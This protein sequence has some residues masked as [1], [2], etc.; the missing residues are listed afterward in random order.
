MDPLAK[1]VR[2]LRQ[3]LGESQQAF[4][5]RLGLS[6][7]AI[8]NYEKDRRPTGMALL[9][10]ARAA[11]A[12]GLGLLT[13][14][15]MSAL[16]EE[17]RLT[18]LPFTWMELKHDG[19]DP[20]GIMLAN[21]KGRRRAEYLMAFWDCLQELDSENLEHQARATERLGALKAAV[22]ADSERKLPPWAIKRW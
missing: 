9:A 17:L 6:I 11:A 5:T 13:D 15:F 22:D 12:A 7:R 1:D 18:E 16:M 10:L 19:K 20:H 14:H 8:A 4:A 3:H 21:V 2:E